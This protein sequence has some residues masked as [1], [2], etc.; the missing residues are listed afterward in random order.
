VHLIPRDGQLQRLFRSIDMSFAA[1]EWVAVTVH[2]EEA[3]GDSI[4]IAFSD[5]HR[6]DAVASAAFNT[7]PPRHE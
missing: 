4:D 1:P 3:L 5:I 2:L 7:A 6:N